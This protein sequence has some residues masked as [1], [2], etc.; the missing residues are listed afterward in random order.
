MDQPLHHD[1]GTAVRDR[2]VLWYEK[3]ASLII[4]LA[5]SLRENQNML[6]KNC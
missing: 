3:L 1:G 4:T 2:L 6:Q 5:A